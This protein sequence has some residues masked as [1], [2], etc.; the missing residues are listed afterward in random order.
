MRA[1]SVVVDLAAET[2][3][4]VEGALA[5]ERVERHGVTL[6]GARNVA[7]TLASDA[8]ALYARNLH[9]LLAAFWDKER[10]EVTLDDEIG[11]AIRLTQ[12]GAVVNE[13]LAG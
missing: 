12:G 4:N 5:G 13:R 3:G 7:A 9:N 1:G 8:S 11:S 10:A 2:G 6:I